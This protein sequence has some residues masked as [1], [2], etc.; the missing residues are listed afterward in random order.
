MFVVNDDQGTSKH[1]CERP[2]IRRSSYRQDQVE[3]EQRIVWTPEKVISREGI[4]SLF[5]DSVNK[6]DDTAGRC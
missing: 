6:F 1:V 5:F 2:K 3:T 4:F